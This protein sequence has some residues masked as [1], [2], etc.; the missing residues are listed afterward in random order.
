[1]TGDTFAPAVAIP[2]W[3]GWEGRH[4]EL[5]P[6]GRS[7]FASAGAGGCAD[8]GQARPSCGRA[9]RA[10]A[11]RRTPGSQYVPAAAVLR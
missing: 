3:P 7:R 8:T 10:G 1:M 2:R 5:A 6:P 9:S 11:G 4:S